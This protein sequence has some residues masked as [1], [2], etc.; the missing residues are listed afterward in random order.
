[1]NIVHSMQIFWLVTFRQITDTLGWVVYP[2][3]QIALTFN[4]KKRKKEKQKEC[5]S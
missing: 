2:T 5:V 4:F 3:M 1:M